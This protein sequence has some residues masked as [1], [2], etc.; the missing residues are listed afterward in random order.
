MSE[1][2]ETPKA[3]TS[4]KIK[5]RI[6]KIGASDDPKAAARQKKKLASSILRQIASGQIKNPVA[7]AKAFVA[8]A[9][10]VT[11]EQAADQA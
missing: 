5:R 1:T 3:L 2:A 9:P 4:K 6:E 8:G 11:P 7:A 10:A